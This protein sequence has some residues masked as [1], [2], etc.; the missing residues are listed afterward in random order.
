MDVLF[1]KSYW[2][3]SHK[4][5][6]DTKA[7]EHYYGMVHIQIVLFQMFIINFEISKEENHLKQTHPLISLLVIYMLKRKVF[8]R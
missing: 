4:H 1:K 6:T 5:V 8:D 3:S 2:I 7:S